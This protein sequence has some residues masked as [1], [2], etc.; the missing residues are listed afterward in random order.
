MITPPIC[1]S[2]FAASTISGAPH[3]KI[4]FQ[5]MKLGFAGYVVPFIFLFNPSLILVTGT[6]KE[7]SAVIMFTTVAIFLVAT[8]FEGYIIKNK[9]NLLTRLLGVVG[10]IILVLPNPAFIRFD[11]HILKISTVLLVLMLI[12]FRIMKNKKLLLKNQ[13]TIEV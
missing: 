10:A 3:L 8:A 2:V 4:A 9:L 11:L 5:A 1:L 7:K 13:K 12:L 6:V